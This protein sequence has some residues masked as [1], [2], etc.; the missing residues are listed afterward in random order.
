MI[1]RAVPAKAA[2]AKEAFENI[3]TDIHEYQEAQDDIQDRFDT[4]VDHEQVDA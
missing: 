3:R 4:R 2:P 1:F